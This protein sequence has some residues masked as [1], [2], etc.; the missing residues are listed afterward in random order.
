MA[1]NSCAKPYTLFRKEKGCPSCGFSYCSKCLHHSLFVNKLNSYAKVCAKCS[2]STDLN[3]QKSLE[4]PDAYYKRIGALLNE[5][6]SA[7]NKTDDEIKKRLL[8]L[9]VDKSNATEPSENSIE[10]RLQKLKGG[11]PSTSDAEL[12]ARLANLRGVPDKNSQNKPIILTAN[13]RTEQQQADDLLQRYMEQAKIDKKYKDGFDKNIEDIETRIQQL[14]GATTKEPTE[15]NKADSDSEDEETEIIKLVEKV[16]AESL[17]L[18]DENI[19][20]STND[21]LP[22]CEICNEDAKMRCLGCQYLFCKRCFMEHK[23]DDDGCNKYE[24]YVPPRPAL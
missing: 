14:K 7:N 1:C 20:P 11:Q 16:K 18:V 21:E 15:I 9:K 13:L 22:F 17:L 10:E 3:K 12:Q 5:D 19:S 6:G 8:K 24:P 4:P 2:N 23:D